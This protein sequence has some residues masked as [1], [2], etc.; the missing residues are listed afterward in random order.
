[1]AKSA[2]AK[3]PATSTNAPTPAQQ[4]PVKGGVIA[5]LT[6]SNASKAADFYVKAFGA[7]E[8]FRHPVDEKGRTMHIHLYIN[9]SSC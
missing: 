5:Y 3:K 4:I 6:V 9:G 7:Q 8:Q 1:M 2:A